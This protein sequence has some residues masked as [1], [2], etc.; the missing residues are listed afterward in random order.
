MARKKKTAPAA[1][2]SPIFKPAE[3]EPMLVNKLSVQEARHLIQCEG[4]ELKAS[5]I[6]IQAVQ[7]VAVATACAYAIWIGQAT[8]WHLA[9]PM[10]GEYLLLLLVMP[11]IYLVVWHE[12]LRKDVVGS[13]RLLAGILLIVAASIAVG[14]YRTGNSWLE[15]AAIDAKQ[16]WAW[17]V[18]HH[19]HW[20]ILCAMGGILLGLPGRIQ[21]LYKY[22]PPFMPVGLGCG[23]RVG[24][25]FLGF[26]LLP[27]IVSGSATRNAWILWTLM[28]IAEILALWMHWDIQRRLR[29]LDGASGDATMN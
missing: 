10:V 27:F 29:K 25:L 24:V 14:S 21:S 4:G 3:D 7:I 12:S 5:Q 17:I 22:G 13:L 26:F 28:L 8:V 23:M 2:V 1:I 6:A 18:D 9:L 20:A 19:M 15:Q 16:S 11:F